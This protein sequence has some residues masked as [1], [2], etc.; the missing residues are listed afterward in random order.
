LIPDSTEAPLHAGQLADGTLDGVILMTALTTSKLP[1]ELARRDIPLVMVNRTVD[2]VTADSCTFDNAAGAAA[3]ARLLAAHGHRR[4]G[5][6]SGP[7]H[8]ST[9]RDRERAFLDEAGRLGIEVPPPLQA[10]G[11]FAFTTGFQATVDFLEVAERPTALFCGNDVIALGACN[12]LAKRGLSQRRDVAVVGFDDIAMAAWPLH[13]LTTLR[14]D[15]QAMARESV[16][17]V[18]RRIRDRR[19]ENEAVVLVPDLV[20]RSSTWPL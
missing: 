11:P 7:T 15:M 13:D 17:L 19:A 18:L 12:A 16:R 6:V 4:V 10:R 1:G 9:G 3:A 5:V 8:M 20:E 2:G 14:C